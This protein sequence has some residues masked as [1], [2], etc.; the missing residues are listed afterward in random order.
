[1]EKGEETDE[2]RI[3][4]AELGSQTVGMI[5]DGV[6]EVL[7]VDEADIDLPSEYVSTVDTKYIT[8]IVKTEEKLIILLE[9]EQLLYVRGR[10]ENPARGEPGE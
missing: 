10:D 1:M 8:G 2:R 4:V 7:E 5:V 9:L 3:V 6:S